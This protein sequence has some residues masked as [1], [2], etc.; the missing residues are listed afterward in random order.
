[1]IFYFDNKSLWI[2]LVASLESIFKAKVFLKV[3][4]L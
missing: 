2:V 4:T 1:M 3:Y